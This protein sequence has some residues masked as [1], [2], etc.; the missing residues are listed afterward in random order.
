MLSSIKQALDYAPIE[1]TVS[2]P[3][4]AAHCLSLSHHTVESIFPVEPRIASPQLSG[5]NA[6]VHYE[7]LEPVISASVTTA[8]LQELSLHV[9]EALEYPPIEPT[10]LKLHAISEAPR[11]IAGVAEKA[12]FS[13]EPDSGAVVNNH[14]TNITNTTNLTTHIDARQFKITTT[15]RKDLPT[16]SSPRNIPTSYASSASVPHDDSGVFGGLS[17]KPR[18]RRTPVDPSDKLGK[19]GNTDTNTLD[20]IT[21]TWPVE[22]PTQNKLSTPSCTTPTT[23]KAIQVTTSGKNL[24]LSSLAHNILHGLMVV[25]AIHWWLIWNKLYDWE[26]ANGVGFDKGVGNVH[27]RYGQYGNGHVLLG[28]L[29]HNLLSADSPLPATAINIITSTISALEGWIGYEPTPLF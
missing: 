24:S 17:M 6:A 1:P 12:G 15:S 23:S 2:N 19:P 3:E 5:V 8:G 26:H 9:D 27:D 29:P 14:I 28:M 16:K 25:L 4:P 22:E 10:H 20:K 7:P 13:L 21:K 18:H 11:L